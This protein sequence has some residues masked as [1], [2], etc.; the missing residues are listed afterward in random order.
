MRWLG[1]AGA[2]EFAALVQK[3]EAWLASRPPQ[4]AAS[5]VQR[6]DQARLRYLAGRDAEARAEGEALD[7]NFPITAF[8]AA[9]SAPARRGAATPKGPGLP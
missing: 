1:R 4:E 2:P 7:A 3:S 8:I 9:L 5:E 6:Y